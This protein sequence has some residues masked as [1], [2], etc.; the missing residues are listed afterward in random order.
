MP[1]LRTQHV[2]LTRIAC[3]RAQDPCPEFAVEH[4][5]QS[6][7]VM[8]RRPQQ[9]LGLNLDEVQFAL[10][11]CS[12]FMWGVPRGHRRSAIQPPV[13]ATSNVSPCSIAA[14]AAQHR[15]IRRPVRPLERSQTVLN[16]RTAS[17]DTFESL[18]TSRWYAH[19]YESAPIYRSA[20]SHAPRR[21][22][23]RPARMRSA[24]HAVKPRNNLTTLASSAA[25]IVRDPGSQRAAGRTSSALVTP[26]KN[27]CARA[28]FARCRIV[29]R[30]RRAVWRWACPSLTRLTE[31]L[32]SRVRRMLSTVVYARL[33]CKY[34]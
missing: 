21:V 11:P 6:M 20:A 33:L 14:L 4:H 16:A 34:A 3:A 19:W 12:T 25:L 27:F 10:Q 1:K 32:R 26:R 28:A 22:P 23:C 31:F 7:N 18:S 13:W 17:N 30:P 5:E 15:L 8:P 29:S 2:L 24:N 9:L